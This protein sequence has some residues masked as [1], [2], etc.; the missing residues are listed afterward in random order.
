MKIIENAIPLFYLKC[1]LVEQS[2]RF[3]ES[4]WFDAPFT[5]V[6]H[7]KLLEYAED[8][9][10]VSN[11]IGAEE[12]SHNPSLGSLP[13]GH[14][15]K[16]EDLYERTGELLYPVCSCIWYLNVKNLVGG[17]LIVEGKEIVPKTNKLVL[18]KPRTWHDISEYKRGTRVG[19]YVNFWDKALNIA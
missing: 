18:L 10:D 5:A 8:F 4:F 12:W 16:D 6:Y 9:T 13:E 2:S 19:L 1:A 15:D 14:Y 3:L 17:N 11:V 7:K